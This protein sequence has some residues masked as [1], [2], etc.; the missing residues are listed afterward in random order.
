[1]T[2]AVGN[3]VAIASGEGKA[4]P[5]IRIMAVGIGALDNLF[6]GSV[7][8]GWLIKESVAV[9]SAGAGGKTAE[10]TFVGSG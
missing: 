8:V 6:T 9:G 10:F 2:V 4:S 1:V 7:A 3:G 5:I